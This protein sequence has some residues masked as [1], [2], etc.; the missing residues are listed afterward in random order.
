MLLMDP[1]SG[2]IGK[3]ATREEDGKTQVRLCLNPGE[4]M[5]VRALADKKSDTTDTPEWPY[6]KPAGEPMPL[7]GTWRVKFVEGGPELPKPFE[8]D[9]LESWT[10]LGGREAERFAGTAVY[11]LTFDA[12]KADPK[13]WRIDLGRVAES[14]M[15]RLNGANLGTH[16][17]AP[18]EMV[19]INLKPKGNVLEVEVT[20]L[21][22]NR[23][24]DLDVRKVQWR[25]FYDIN[26][27][28]IQYRPFDASQWPVRDSGLLGPVT[29]QP[30]EQ[31]L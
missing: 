10:K 12:P 7:S 17:L 23:I 30:M 26:F 5:L 25:Y 9:N 31:G 13:A 24:R 16:I 8:T 20:N 2:R 29:I 6:W 19:A 27:V 4:S 22:A 28:N 15:V 14:A 18:F 3:A 11:R 21:S 1:F